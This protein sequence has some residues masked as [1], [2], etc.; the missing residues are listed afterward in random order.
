LIGY[1]KIDLEDRYFDSKWRD[2]AEK[3]IEVRPLKHPDFEQETGRVSLWVEMFERNDGRLNKK[4]FINP[5][6]K[7]ELEMRLVV[8]E[9]KNTPCLD[10]EDM[11]DY[12]FTCFV[13]PSERQSTDVHFR[14]EKGFS[15]SFNWR[16][17]LPIHAPTN[18][19][20][21]NIR[22]MDNDFFSKDDYGADTTLELRKLI[23]LVYELDVPVKFTKEFYEATKNSYYNKIEFDSENPERFWLNMKRNGQVNFEN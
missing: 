6:P 16:I 15:P 5:A 14:C 19:D 17:I 9:G 20:L 3:P 8:W 4:W 11:S 13:N 7:V 1:T 21:L 18:N 10:V 23:D 2:L 22:L 12:Y